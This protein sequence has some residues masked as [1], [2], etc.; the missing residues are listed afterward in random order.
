MKWYGL[1]N[2]KFINNKFAHLSIYKNFK[3]KSLSLNL[4]V[5]TNLNYCYHLFYL[6]AQWNAV[7]FKIFSQKMLK[8]LIYIYSTVYFFYLPQLIS[9]EF[10]YDAQMKIIQIKTFFFNNFYKLY[11]HRFKQL[12]YSFNFFF[13]KKLNLKVKGIIF[14]KIFVIRLLCNLGILT[15]FNFFF[16]ILILNFY[17]K[18][19]FFFLE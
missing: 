2:A 13:L 7:M 9:T 17:L 3:I 19:Q 15:K 11:W 6:P 5:H 10:Y 4:K 12:F 8:S 16:S 14:I 18:P 1:T